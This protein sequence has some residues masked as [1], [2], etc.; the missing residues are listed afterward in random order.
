MSELLLPD[1][2]STGPALP[3][4]SRSNSILTQSFFGVSQL[5]SPLEIRHKICSLEREMWRLAD[6]YTEL[7]T[8]HMFSPGVYLRK[9]FIKKGETVVGKIH[10]HE[11]ANIISQGIVAVMTEFGSAIYQAHCMFTSPATTKRALV[12]LE[13]TIWTVIHLNPTNTRDLD[14]LERINIAK[15]YTELG[16]EDPVLMLEGEK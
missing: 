16:M 2:F 8:E 4:D 7:P 13:D 6:H 14:E 15:S 10:R 5:A 12:A 11:H 9:C 3:R 1:T